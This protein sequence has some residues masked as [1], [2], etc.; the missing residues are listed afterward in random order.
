MFLAYQNLLVVQVCHDIARDLAS[1][2]QNLSSIGELSVFLPGIIPQLQKLNTAGTTLARVEAAIRSANVEFGVVVLDKDRTAIR[3]R[4]S[5]LH[6]QY[7][8]LRDRQQYQ[9]NQAQESK[10][11]VERYQKT[12]QEINQERTQL[13]TL[14]GQFIQ[15]NVSDTEKSNEIVQV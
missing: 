15:R 5:Q 14:M 11:R 8:A 4:K 7:K 1:V 9:L 10:A 2:G 13:V 12:N 3:D 6:T